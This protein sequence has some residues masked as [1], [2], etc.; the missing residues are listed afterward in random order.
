MNMAFPKPDMTLAERLFAQLQQM[1]FDGKG[2]T[3][4]AYGPGEQAAHN[5]VRQLASE[6]GFEVVTDAAA[7]L[8]VILPGTNRK[9]KRVVIGSH[10]DSVP[11]G[12]NYDGAAG[13]LAGLAIVAGWKAEG[14]VPPCDIVVM[15]IRAE[16]SAWF[17]IS[18]LGSKASLGKLTRD[19]LAIVRRDNQISI[20]QHIR[21]CGGNPDNVVEKA[22]LFGADSLR[23]FLEIHIE[24]GPV[25]ESAEIPVGIVSGICGSLRYR[26]ASAY[27][28]YAHSGACPSYCR[29]D[30]VVATA[31]LVTEMHRKWHE[32][33]NDGHELT[34][35][36]GR[37]FTDPIDADMSKV[38]GLVK[39]SID[40]RSRNPATLELVNNHLL[41]FADHLTE[42]HG[43]QFE[44]GEQSRSAPA[45][46]DSH[47]IAAFEHSA[48][49]L[50][51]ANR[52]MPS[53]A[54]HDCA[55]FVNCGVPGA[56]LFI[57]NQH[58]SHNPDEAMEFADFN[59]A[60]TVLNHAI[61]TELL[62]L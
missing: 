58:G 32:M 14:L 7:N 35:T 25:L 60:V 45:L 27:G 17:P 49:V 16:E 13:V 36:F 43:V 56:M 6:L 52:L 61:V 30:A 59:Q 29:Q 26:F 48:T 28:Q 1:S 39:F 8:Y 22:P 38:S 62:N 19:D 37:M 50:N 4:D 57:R 10:L 3:R 2:I 34:V 9:A 40:F 21:S 24:Q 44:F 33:E 54:G 5:L 18:Y 12:G 15:A 31:E 53:G 46:M 42:R 55:Q 23:A 11:S 51:I 47:W 41:M 20:D